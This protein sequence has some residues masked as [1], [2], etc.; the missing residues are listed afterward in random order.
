M[1]GYLVVYSYLLS[2]LAVSY[3]IKC[4]QNTQLY[5]V[6]DEV[7]CVCTVIYSRK[8]IT[9]TW[10][11]CC[12][13][14]PTSGHSCQMRWHRQRQRRASQP[15]ISMYWKRYDIFMITPT[16]E[17]YLFSH[18]V[19]YTHTL[20]CIHPQMPTH[21][22]LTFSASML[23]LEWQQYS[24]DVGPATEQVHVQYASRHTLSL[25]SYL[26]IHKFQ[27]LQIPHLFCSIIFEMGT[28]CVPVCH[29]CTWLVW[30]TI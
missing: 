25:I 29:T 15:H 8:W 22:S 3:S 7:I 5:T 21:F 23:P 26:F 13:A 20:P 18:T 19:T 14:G 11:T 6:H 28:A 10:C 1:W 9:I 17:Y 2:T 30:T 12:S 16:T 4:P 27:G 24:E